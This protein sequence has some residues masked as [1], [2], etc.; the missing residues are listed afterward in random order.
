MFKHY[1]QH[2]GSKPKNSEVLQSRTDL[3]VSCGRMVLVNAF[4]LLSFPLRIGAPGEAT[5]RIERQASILEHMAGRFGRVED[6][7]IRSLLSMGFLPTSALPEPMHKFE[8]RSAAKGS[9]GKKEI[10]SQP[11]NVAEVQYDRDG[12]VQSSF[13]EVCD[14]LGISTVGGEVRLRTPQLCKRESQTNPQCPIAC[15][16]VIAFNLPDVTISI[17]YEDKVIETTVVSADSLL[18]APEKP[19]AAEVIDLYK[20]KPDGSQSNVARAEFDKGYPKYAMHCVEQVM[21]NASY[22]VARSNEDLQMT[23]LSEE[24]K[25][26]LL[27]QL[28]VRRAFKKHELVLPPFGGQLLQLPISPGVIAAAEKM[29]DAYIRGVRGKVITTQRKN[30][31]SPEAKVI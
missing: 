29:H 5:R 9:G 25:L 28:R 6:K 8:P 4:Q 12:N 14:R 2:P 30:K 23:I 26:P 1:V 27:V 7:Y 19:S 21:M 11:K 3:L 17:T 15:V 22:A 16:N 10:G 13:Q 31:N 20:F 18:A 24:G